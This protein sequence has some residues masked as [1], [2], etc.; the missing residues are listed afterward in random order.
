MVKESMLSSLISSNMQVLGL[1]HVNSE[2]PKVVAE[3]I[4]KRTDILCFDLS[5]S[6]P[7]ILELKIKKDTRVVDQLQAYIDLVSTKY[8]NLFEE[9]NAF[10]QTDG[11]HFNYDRGIV[12]M[13][14]SPEP[15]PSSIQDRGSTIVW[16]QFSKT[17]LDNDGNFRIVAQNTLS[18]SVG[19]F[20]Q[21]T[22]RPAFKRLWPHQFVSPSCPYLRKFV[23]RL[24]HMYLS[25][26]DRIYP[27]YR[28]DY[29]YIA[30]Y[31]TDTERNSAVYGFGTGNDQSQFDVTFHVKAQNHNDFLNHRACKELGALGLHMG[32]PRKEL[33]FPVRIEERFASDEKRVSQALALFKQLAVFAYDR[34]KVPDLQKLHIDPASHNALALKHFISF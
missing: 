18:S 12:G 10:R 15:A 21:P 28:L 23:D 4:G 3:H 29:N 9:L 17:Q 24:D 25:I 26:S 16:A 11:F 30:Y 27:R 7:I 33:I 1:H 8:P 34:A 13:V 5:T 32:Y 14:L 6:I 20:L 22:S 19:A 31:G 2:V